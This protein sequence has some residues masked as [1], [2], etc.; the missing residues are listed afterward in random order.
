MSKPERQKV[1][2]RV[3]RTN[4]LLME[5]LVS[6]AQEKD[7]DAIT[8]RDITERADVSYSTFFRHYRDKEELMVYVLETINEEIK[9]ILG[10][11]DFENAEVVGKA[12]FERVQTNIPVFRI[13]LRSRR[14]PAVAKRLSSLAQSDVSEAH[15][16]ISHSTVPPEIAA[17][18]T[19]TSALS[20]I[21]WWLEN[22]MP[23]TPE[24]MGQIYSDLIIKPLR[25]LGKGN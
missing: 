1:D 6:L 19:M 14:S 18:H 10:Q 16:G 4:R 25:E 2:R 3:K 9:S 23:Y 15:P 5:S 12:I 8:I 11:L 24:R 21:D 13:L 20:L 7:Y 22:G 17:Y